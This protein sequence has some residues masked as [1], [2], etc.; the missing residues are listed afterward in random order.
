MR[1]KGIPAPPSLARFAQKFLEAIMQNIISKNL[2][3]LLLFSFLSFLAIWFIP[4]IDKVLFPASEVPGVITILGVGLVITFFVIAILYFAVK[5]SLNIPGQFLLFAVLYNALVVI[6]KFSLAP[7]SLYVANQSRTFEALF[8]A[9][10]GG[11]G[12]DPLILSIM[13]A[14]VFLLYFVVF[15]FIYFLFK[16]K[17]KLELLATDSQ[18]TLAPKHKGHKVLVIIGLALLVGIIILAGGGAIFMFPLFFA[19]FPALQYLGYVFS[20]WVSLFMALALVGAIYFVTGA[21]KTAKEQALALRDVSVLVSFFW[22][23]A[24]FLFIYHALWVVYLLILTALWPLRV[25]V[26]K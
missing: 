25:V 5:N 3:N 21:F 22:I 24:A 20:T 16:R 11:G 6:V 17:L 13:T 15:W 26:P 23:G 7:Y 2:I 4:R 14:L 9:F 12:A 10:T 18:A 19:G 1:G 8:S